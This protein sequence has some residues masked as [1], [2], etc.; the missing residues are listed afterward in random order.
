MKKLKLLILFALSVSIISCRNEE[1]R[2]TPYDS[3]F[4]GIK[5][6]VKYV[7]EQV[8]YK[9][10]KLAHTEQVNFDK[11]G[12]ISSI[13]RI[14]ED[15]DTVTSFLLYEKSGRIREIQTDSGIRLLPAY[16]DAG[17]L[18]QI[19]K[20]GSDGTQPL[21]VQEFEY[22]PDGNVVLNKS[23]NNKS[24]CRT[25]E[26]QYQNGKLEKIEETDG[27]GQKTLYECDTTGVIVQKQVQAANGK[28][29]SI[30]TYKYKYGES[31]NWIEQV[32]REN[33]NLKYTVKREI[34]YY[35]DAEMAEQDAGEYSEVQYK[36]YFQIPLIDNFINDVIARR[37]ESA[38]PNNVLLI[39][40]IICTLAITVAGC[41]MFSGQL[42]SNFTGKVQS[43][44]MKRLWM[45][46]VEPYAKV[47]T[48]LLIALVA[49]IASILLILLVGGL[50]WGILWIVKIILWAI[51]VIG[52]LVLIFGILS[53]W[54]KE[55]IGCLPLIIGLLVVI[56]QDAIKET[57]ERLVRIGFEFMQSVNMFN[58]G[59]EIFKNY[60]D[61][62]LVMYLSPM[63][64]FLLFAIVVIAL[65][66][67][68][69]GL[70]FVITRIYSIRRPC[71][72]CGSTS[73]PEY[74]IGGKPHP[75]RLQPGMYGVFTHTSPVTGE[76]VPTML[77]NGRGKIT[78]RCK[79]CNSYIKSNAENS[80]GTEIHIGIVGHR[81]SGKSYLLY[82]GLA[83]LME[84]WPGRFT[85]IDEE[86]DIKIVNKK[87]SID[88]RSGIQTSVANK[89]RAVQLILKSKMRPL[90]YHLFFYDVA[91]EKFN[92]N[93][94]SHKTALEFYKNV[95]SIVFV[96]DPGMVELTG[97]PASD[98][99]RE[100]SRKNGSS[101][102]YNVDS[103][104]AVLKEILEN[105]GRKSNKLDLNFVCTKADTGYLT[106]LGY[107]RNPSE[108]EIEQF[109]SREAGLSNLVNSARASFREIH[110]YAVSAVD[111]DKKNLI[112]M[113]I[114]LLEQRN[115]SI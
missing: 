90:P 15:N 9:N 71:P 23:C 51:I 37:S 31:G 78:R 62:I 54:G 106:E 61:V 40:L 36:A 45:Y 75:V 4:Y 8:Y 33:R 12:R 74:I 26:Y 43:N 44:G 72:I 97:K 66:M 1:S 30:S 13:T 55:P 18:V 99:F 104:L 80:F 52:W 17:D 27:S 108:N 53:L 65:N 46:N 3:G 60:W 96:I 20:V 25:I 98:K 11:K 115:V 83:S 70:E 103:A 49:F 107:P 24:E 92:A 56:N 94:A 21:S 109:I 79:K 84:A 91:G 111:S 59:L 64:L 14:T 114:S 47:G 7:I 6:N 77:L 85:Q 16:N 5:G 105:A 19:T 88:A 95:Q 10:S 42:F 34:A 63:V 113:F 82:S 87:R 29:T 2:Y 69:N 86:D 68:L 112:N 28:Q 38:S 41:Y 57:G 39:I 32:E 101:E 67:L 76:K 58:W 102:K 81:A 35:T 93:T 100:W 73:T 110:F 50:I 48:I 89:Y 22:D